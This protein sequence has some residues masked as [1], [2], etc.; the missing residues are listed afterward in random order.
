MTNR[1]HND[2]ASLPRETV[3]GTYA[4][5][6]DEVNRLDKERQRIYIDKK[7][8]SDIIKYAVNKIQEP[9]VIDEPDLHPNL[10]QA[11][12]EKREFDRLLSIR[13][14]LAA[15]LAVPRHRLIQA[16]R[17]FYERLTAHKHASESPHLAAEIEMFSRFFEMQAM[18]M[19]YDQHR[20]LHHELEAARDALL[21]TVKAINR[22]DRKFGQRL[23]SNS[24]QSRPLRREAGRLRAYLKGLPGANPAPLPEQV[25]EFTLRLAAGNSLS[26]E[27]FAAMLDHGG[28]TNFEETEAPEM[29]PKKRQAR[30]MR[31]APPMRGRRRRDGPGD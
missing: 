21:E 11:I 1:F 9:P 24:E 5:T 25:E 13:D 26:M 23:N 15:R 29:A 7:L 30:T 19:A 22:E 8:R 10:V 3:E 31:R 28:L 12:E 27:E 18:V 4:S 17:S 20:S 16:M 6:L 14:E 2:L